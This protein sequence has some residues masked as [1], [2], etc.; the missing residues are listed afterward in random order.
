MIAW[1]EPGI[2][3]SPVLWRRGLPLMIERGEKKPMITGL[4][5]A[6][7]L[8]GCGLIA[9]DSVSLAAG[10]NPKLATYTN[11]RSGISLQYPS[12]YRA[13]KSNEIPKF[14]SNEGP[15]DTNFIQP[16]AVMLVALVPPGGLTPGG[17]ADELLILSVNPKITA[18]EC[19]RFDSPP[20]DKWMP[21][22]PRSEKVGSMEFFQSDDFQGG[23]CHDVDYKY[24]HV[25]RNQA[26]YEIEMGVFVSPCVQDKDHDVFGYTKNEFKKLKEILATLTIRPAT[27]AK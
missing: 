18:K 14:W 24:Y 6:L 4:L 15:I 3:P 21:R 17:S 13:L 7:A 2:G 26:C 27:I 8:V 23:M 10:H 5:A 11:D 25:F 9:L 20:P 22:R 12:D 16:G 19:A 1:K